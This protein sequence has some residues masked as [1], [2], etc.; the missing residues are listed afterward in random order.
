MRCRLPKW[1]ERKRQPPPFQTFSE[2]SL[3][4]ALRMGQG[5]VTWGSPWRDPGRETDPSRP[6]ALREAAQGPGSE[7]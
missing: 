7:E 3:V 5:E 1:K 4:L 2:P 6:L